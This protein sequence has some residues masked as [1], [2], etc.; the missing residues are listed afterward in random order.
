MIYKKI[1]HFLRKKTKHLTETV[2]SDIDIL[3]DKHQSKVRTF[4]QRLIE[5]MYP[6]I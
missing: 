1:I 3:M 6:Q 4:E 5:S 2:L